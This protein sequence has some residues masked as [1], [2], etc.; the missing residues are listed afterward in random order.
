MVV[1]TVFCLE[2]LQGSQ[3]CWWG[4]YDLKTKLEEISVPLDR[5]EEVWEST[6]PTRCKMKKREQ[7]T[8]PLLPGTSHL[9]RKGKEKGCQDNHKQKRHLRSVTEHL[10]KHHM[11]WGELWPPTLGWA[12][13]STFHTPI[14]LCIWGPCQEARES[15]GDER[16]AYGRRSSP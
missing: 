4:K 6:H 11:W 15:E 7:V 8:L 9:W 1:K 5:H 13:V 3:P 14:L 10:W 16:Q 12:V 2:H